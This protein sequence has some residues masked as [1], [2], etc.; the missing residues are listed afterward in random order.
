MFSGRTSRHLLWFSEHA[1]TALVVVWCVSLIL[2]VMLTLRSDPAELPELYS[3]A[4]TYF[5]PARSLIEKGEFR[6][7]TGVP[8]VDRTPGYPLFLAAIMLLVGQDFRTVLIV[9]AVIL[10]AGPVLLYV[11]AKKLLPPFKA[12]LAALLAAVSPWGAV[13]AGIPM[14]DGLFLFLLIVIF[15]AMKQFQNSTFPKQCIGA[16]AVG[17]LTG[18]AVL[19]RPIW[20]LVI[21]I[22]LS[23]SVCYGHKRAG[24]WLLGLISLG[25]AVGPVE[26]WRARNRA[27]AHFESLSDIPGKTAWRYL[28]AR[29]RAETTGQNRHD[30][31]TTAYA[32]EKSWTV[33]LSRQEAD[34]ERWRRAKAVFAEHPLVTIFSFA[35]S[36]LEHGIHPSPDVLRAAKLNFTGDLV[37]FAAVWGLMLIASSLVLVR[38][39]VD[40]YWRS[41]VVEWP[42]VWSMLAICLFL[43]LCSGISFAAGSRLRAPMEAV[44]PLLTALGFARIADHI[45]WLRNLA[46]KGPIW[47]ISKSV[48]KP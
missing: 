33:S 16:V 12:W 3:D 40:I 4:G 7:W 46:L 34:A 32:E 5:A 37:V 9:Q 26:L 42:W 21:L 20:P 47:L 30:M 17:A 14:S 18:F 22:P 31:S 1:A 13:L 29:V 38:S 10:S 11:L 35:R 45:S 44:V 25:C 2:R 15:L 19:V 39:W 48:I 41:G 36:A 6:E 43:T 23:Y 28:A 8:M 24:V 27:V